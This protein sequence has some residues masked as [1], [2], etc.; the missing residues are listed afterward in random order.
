MSW[1]Q[2]LLISCKCCAIELHPAPHN[3]HFILFYGVC[4]WVHKC[5]WGV[6]VC[7]CVCQCGGQREAP[8]VHLSPH[9]LLLRQV[10]ARW[11]H[12]SLCS[13]S[14]HSCPSILGLELLVWSHPL[15]ISVLELWAQ[16]L[17]HR[18]HFLPAE[19]LPGWGLACTLL[20]VVSVGC[21]SESYIYLCVCL[22]C[23]CRYWPVTW[24]WL[25]VEGVSFLPPPFGTWVSD[26][27]HQAWQY[28]SF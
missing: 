14:L 17:F 21:W 22:L 4:M 25:Q 18:E 26:L 28:F 27:V 15:F 11:S 2:G 10:G 6:C 16:V 1:H 8:S 3:W 9:L 24:M 19:S 5:V 12:E 23:L 7:T 13:V 20:F